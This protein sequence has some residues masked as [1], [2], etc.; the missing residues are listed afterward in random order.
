MRLTNPSRLHSSTH[1]NVA[2]QISTALVGS[3]SSSSRSVS[4]DTLAHATRC[5]RFSFLMLPSLADLD[6]LAND[7]KHALQHLNAKVARSANEEPFTR[8]G[9]LGCSVA[10]SCLCKLSVQVD[11]SIN[12]STNS[13]GATDVGATLLA[14][15]FERDGILVVA[16]LLEVLAIFVW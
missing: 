8:P 6:K 9:D 5:G 4:S 2:L 12:L 16:F 13:W 11:M 15:S 7:F 10:I 1:F 3:E 14:V